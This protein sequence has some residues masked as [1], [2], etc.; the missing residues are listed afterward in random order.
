[1]LVSISNFEWQARFVLDDQYLSTATTTYYLS[2]VSELSVTEQLALGI[3]SFKVGS[4]RYLCHGG[5]CTT[6][7]NYIRNKTATSRCNF[8]LLSITQISVEQLCEIGSR[9]Y[10][11]LI[12][13][14]ICNVSELLLLCFI[15]QYNILQ[16]NNEHNVGIPNPRDIKFTKIIP[17]GCIFDTPISLT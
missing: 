11:R 13:R 6:S 9:K 10:T 14:C 16:K 15:T 5:T 8:F 2:S 7:P 12:T 17:A 4:I 3:H 1:M